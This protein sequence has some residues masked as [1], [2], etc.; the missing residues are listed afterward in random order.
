MPLYM[1][2]YTLLAQFL[3]FTLFF[4]LASEFLLYQ[5]VL[6][7][8]HFFKIFCLTAFFSFQFFL[9]YCNTYLTLSHFYFSGYMYDFLYIYSSFW[10]VIS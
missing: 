4:G 7:L 1:E 9:V 2:M 6:S 8:F 3:L 5:W 10:F